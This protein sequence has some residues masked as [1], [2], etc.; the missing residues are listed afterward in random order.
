MIVSGTA[1][2][3]TVVALVAVMAF[4]FWVVERRPHAF[5]SAE[6]ARWVI[7]YVTLAGLFAMYLLWQYGTGP[8]GE[9]VAGYI[10]EYSL[11][12]DN[13]FVFV[14][15]MGS[16]A[17]P[18]ALQHRVLLIGVVLALVLRTGLIFVG[19]AVLTRFT[20]TFYL[21][22]AFLI[23]TA[24]RVA[25]SHEEEADPEGN[26]LVRWVEKR[27][28]VTREYYGHQWTAIINGVRHITPMALVILAIPF[29]QRFAIV[30]STTVAH[31]LQLA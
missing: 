8:A 29:Q 24:W 20:V 11:S 9:F 10:T 3:I 27:F 26:A 30:L 21:F 5:T 2:A 7:A 12:V 17:V 6:A 14:V 31:W 16:F 19:A 15:L 4:D 18:A 1:W 13:L 22:G 25:T 23:W 28:P